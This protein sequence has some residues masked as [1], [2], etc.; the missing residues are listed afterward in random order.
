MTDAST[1]D[2]GVVQ[3]TVNW[4][5][6]TV[7]SSDTTPPFGPFVHTYISPGTWTLTHRAIDTIGQQSS[8]TCKADP[9]YFTIGGTVY[10]SDG[11]TPVS[12][13]MIQVRRGGTLVRTVYSTALGAYSVG[14]LRPGT[15]TLTVTKSGYVF[16]TVPPV[17][18]GPSNLAV[19]I[20][21]ISPL[22]T[23]SRR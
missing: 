5:D 10:R 4:G 2:H 13:A 14:S 23:G 11:R 22:V 1:D 7:I 8:R 15:Y 3:V 6:G 9:A 19:N 18:V 20:V 16:P 21:A 12:S 17:T